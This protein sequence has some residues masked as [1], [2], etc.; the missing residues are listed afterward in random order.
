[1]T[2][3]QELQDTV[4]KMR[5]WATKTTQRLEILEEITLPNEKGYDH[6]VR[7]TK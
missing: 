2:E 7:P 4:Q 6:V 1:M 3:I 5:D